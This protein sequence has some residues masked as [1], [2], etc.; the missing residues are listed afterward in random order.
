MRELQWPEVADAATERWRNTTDPRIHIVMKHILD[1]YEPEWEKV[2]LYQY[3]AH[4]L[5]KK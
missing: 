4:E 3:Y 5:D 1:V 2:D